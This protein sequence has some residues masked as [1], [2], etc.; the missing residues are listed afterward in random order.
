MNRMAS[1]KKSDHFIGKS[2]DFVGDWLEK[3]NLAKLKPLFEGKSIYKV[4]NFFFIE[5]LFIN[6]A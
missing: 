2:L 1:N 3:N 4:V 6:A 5:S